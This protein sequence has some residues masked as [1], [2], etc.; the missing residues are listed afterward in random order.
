LRQASK[1]PI[2]KWLDKK[3]PQYNPAW[4]SYLKQVDNFAQS[5]IESLKEG[6]KGKVEKKDD[7]W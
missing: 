6:M 4:N 1:I 3:D 2:E 7:E 5:W